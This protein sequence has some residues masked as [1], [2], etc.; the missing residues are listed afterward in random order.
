MLKYKYEE[1]SKI[2]FSKKLKFKNSIITN[3]LAILYKY[4][5]LELVNKY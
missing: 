1:K 3:M 5:K 4:F 2:L